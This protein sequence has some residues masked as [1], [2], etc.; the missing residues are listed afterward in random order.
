MAWEAAGGDR[1]GDCLLNAAL[2][3][4]P[5][6]A[7][8]TQALRHREGRAS[9]IGRPPELCRTWHP[10]R[11]QPQ[12]LRDAWGVGSLCGRGPLCKGP[13]ARSRDQA[14]QED[15]RC[16]LSQKELGQEGDRE[17]ARGGCRERRGGGD[18]VWHL[19]R[20]RGRA[21][22]SQLGWEPMMEKF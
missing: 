2:K 14:P 8:H 12:D 4:G 22:R 6:W 16:C 10:H 20:L 1:G 11:L 7:G 19:P 21:R 9:G 13:K 3:Q 17:G 15:H 5:R 18:S